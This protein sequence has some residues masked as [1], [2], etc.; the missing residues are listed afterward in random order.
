MRVIIAARIFPC[1]HRAFIRLCLYAVIVNLSIIRL[2][3]LDV[4]VEQGVRVFFQMLVVQMTGNT[5]LLFTFT[6]LFSCR[7]SQLVISL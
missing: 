5:G 4:H 7:R 6:I 3:F 2:S 1:G